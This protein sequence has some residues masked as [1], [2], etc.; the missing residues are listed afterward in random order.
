MVRSKEFD[1]EEALQKALEVFQAKGFDGA[2]IRDLVEAMG[3]NRQSLYDTYG[4]KE[5]LYHTALNRYRAQAPVRIGSFVESALPLRLALAAQFEQV[6]DYLLS[7]KSRSCL[8]AQAALVRAAKDPE[9]AECVRSAFCQN[10]E[11]LERRLRRAQAEGEL[12]LHHDPAALARFFQNA[13]HGFQ[14]T[15]RSGASREELDAIIRVNL[16]ILG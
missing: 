1:T 7:P 9:S 5:T 16:S 8:L 15:A 2:S 14:V 4:D 13:M 11:R 12:G 10:V 6:I 3:I